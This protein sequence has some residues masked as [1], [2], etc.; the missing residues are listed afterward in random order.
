MTRIYEIIGKLLKVIDE[1]VIVSTYGLPGHLIC[2]IINFKRF[3]VAV[4]KKTLNNEQVCNCP[5]IS[6]MLESKR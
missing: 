5:I 2:L 6:S 3:M 4:Y 1:D